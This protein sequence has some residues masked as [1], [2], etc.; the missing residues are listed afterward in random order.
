MFLFPLHI[1]FTGESGHVV[2]STKPK[3]LFCDLKLLPGE[4]KTCKLINF[5]N[6]I[7]NFLI[8]FN[9][10]INFHTLKLTCSVLMSS[11]NINVNKHFWFSLKR[12]RHSSDYFK[13]GK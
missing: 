6:A 1:F 4:S 9:E 13:K 8:A 10:D 5:V 12:F 7:F 2:L 11:V 3:I